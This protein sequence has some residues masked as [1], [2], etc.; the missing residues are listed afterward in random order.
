MSPSQASHPKTALHTA[1]SH[2][3]VVQAP[4]IQVAPRH[5]SA[6]M[7]MPMATPENMPTVRSEAPIAAMRSKT[8]LEMKIRLKALAMPAHRRSSI[9]PASASDQ[10][11]AASNSA[12][13]A[14]PTHSNRSC[15]RR[16]RTAVA[17]SAPMRYPRKLALA[18][19]PASVMDST[20]AD[21][22]SGRI[23]V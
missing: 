9:Q 12:L 5:T 8:R 13:P 1:I 4:P 10:A 21:S 6:E 3:W 20:P 15:R 14:K 2:H 7:M 19:Q 23:G 17:T 16:S 22:M 11:M 18:T